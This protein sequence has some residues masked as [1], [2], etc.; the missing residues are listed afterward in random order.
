MENAVFDDTHFMNNDY[1]ESNLQGDNFSGGKNNFSPTFVNL[2]SE[3]GENF[4]NYLKHLDL[5]KENNIMVLSSNHHY[6]YDSSDL[7][8]I[9]TLVNLKK[10]NLIKNLD[11]FLHILF[12][13]L[14]SNANFIGCFSE[15]NYRNNIGLIFNQPAKLLS[16][17]INF[18]D[19]RIDHDMNKDDVSKIFEL[20]GFKVVDMTEINGQ[21]FFRTRKN[22]LPV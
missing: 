3:G 15:S 13:I 8:D 4:F 6:Y 16:K 11:R 17:I 9:R 1:N 14:P 22:K 10:L 21:T 19:S 7:Q 2:I 5:A 12:R 20:H 18:L